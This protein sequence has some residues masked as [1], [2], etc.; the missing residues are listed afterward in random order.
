MSMLCPKCSGKSPCLETRRCQDDTVR[1]RYRCNDCGCRFISVEVIVTVDRKKH[2]PELSRCPRS[3]SND[4]R[5]AI[6]NEESNGDCHADKA[7]L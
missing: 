6:I 7:V 2:A 3:R 4:L 5:L 1:R